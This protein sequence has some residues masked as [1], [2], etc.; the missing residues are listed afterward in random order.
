MTSLLANDHGLRL[1][2]EQD[3]L[4]ALSSGLPAC[5]F[6]PADLHPDF[7]VL[8]NG[9]AGGILQKFVNYG[10]HVAFV[11]RADHAYGPRITELMRDHRTHPCIRFFETAEEAS[12][13]GLNAAE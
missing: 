9:I 11:V 10:F 2:T 3:A 6:T 1:D 5:V 13:W 4:D 8:S 12:S 7:F